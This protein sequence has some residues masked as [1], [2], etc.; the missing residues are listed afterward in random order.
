MLVEHVWVGEL[1]IAHTH[2][3]QA[4]RSDTTDAAAAHDSDHRVTQAALPLALLDFGVAEPAEI[5]PNAFSVELV[6]VLSGVAGSLKHVLSPL[7]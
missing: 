4:I 6:V 2:A 1:Q 7:N 3:D 5:S